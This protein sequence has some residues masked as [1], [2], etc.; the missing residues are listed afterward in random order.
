MKAKSY[1]NY[2]DMF[3]EDVILIK[4]NRRMKIIPYS[5]YVVLF[6]AKIN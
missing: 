3:K 2:W 4:L 5:P 6:Y 1:Y